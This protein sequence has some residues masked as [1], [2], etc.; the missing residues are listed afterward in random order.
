MSVG[1]VGLVEYLAIA[2]EVTRL[3]SDTITKVA[4]VDLAD[5]AL[6]AP[7]AGFGDTDFYPDF[8]DKAAVLVVRLVKNHPLPDGNKR[9]AWVALRMFVEINGW[10]WKPTPTV[11]EAE[12][13]MLAIASGEWDRDE[14]ARWLGKNL[15]SPED[16]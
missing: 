14:M 13:A 12:R 9:A 15:A 4:S 10:P 6:H 16:E 2:A 3:D 5:S 1:Y 11:D 8:L 7:A